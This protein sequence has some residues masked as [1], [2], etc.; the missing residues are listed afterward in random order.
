MRKTDIFVISANERS[1][2]YDGKALQ[3]QFLRSGEQLKELRN[4]LGAT[5]REVE[6]YSRTIAEDSQNP[7][8]YISNAWLTQI[9]NRNSVPSIYKLY[10]MSVIYR[11]K[12]QDLLAVFGVNLN[13]TA[14]SQPEFPRRGTYLASVESPHPEKSITFPVRLDRDFN[15]ESTRLIARMVEVWREVPIALIQKLDIRNC[16]YGYIGASDFTMYP[17]LRPALLLRSVA[18]LVAFKPRHGIRSSIGPSIL[19]SYATDTLVRGAR[20]RGRKSL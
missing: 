8:F 7:E 16:Q 15:L 9:E 13:S 17:L 3:V 19:W 1:F 5:I 6:E 10:S 2:S 14:R 11:T 12:L 4:R 20:F 18:G